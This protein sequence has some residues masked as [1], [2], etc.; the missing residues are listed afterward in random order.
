MWTVKA[1]GGFREGADRI[2]CQSKA[3]SSKNVEN[4]L[5]WIALVAGRIGKERSN[6]EG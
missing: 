2:T 5:R 6:Q 4:S 3:D 1:S